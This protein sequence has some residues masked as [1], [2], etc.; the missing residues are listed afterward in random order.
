M[1]KGR[2]CLL[3]VVG[4]ALVAC[5][6]SSSSGAGSETRPRQEHQEA[7]EELGP[8]GQQELRDIVSTGKLEGMQWPN[9]ADHIASVKEVLR[10]NRLQ[11]GMES[12]R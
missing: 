2:V 5:S 9:F 10:R 11:A 4:L 1:N 12:E 3:L 7:L 6:H 8:A